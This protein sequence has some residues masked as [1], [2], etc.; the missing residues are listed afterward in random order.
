MSWFGFF[1]RRLKP[2]E[3]VVGPFT[4]EDFPCPDP[5]P[6]GKHHTGAYSGWL[7]PV[8]TNDEIEFA[9]VIPRGSSDAEEL[10]A[11]GEQLQVWQAGNGIV[12]R[13]LGLDQLLEGHFPETPGY[14]FGL[15][16]PPMTERV[17]LVYVVP[18]AN[19]EQTGASLNQALEGLSVAAVVSPA[20]Y[21]QIN[22]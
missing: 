21:S 1:K 9:V 12:R 16:M 13:I 3:P 5:R 4:P 6:G 8:A 11:I 14:L 22:R 18:S 2:T 10:K 17:A 20:Y 15:P 19:N 7:D